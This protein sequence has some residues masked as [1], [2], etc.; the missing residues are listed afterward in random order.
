MSQVNN[1]SENNENCSLFSNE[2]NVKNEETNPEN[3][4]EKKYLN[5]QNKFIEN[6]NFTKIKEAALKN[7]LNLRHNDMM[8]LFNQRRIFQKK[9]YENLDSLKNKIKIPIELFEE[10]Q[11]ITIDYNQIGKYFADFFSNDISLKYKSLVCL[12]KILLSKA[13]LNEEEIA[14]IK[15][16][17][18]LFSEVQFLNDCFLLLNSS[19]PEFQYEAL[20]CL[21]G[22]INCIEE[23]SNFI[24]SK[25]GLNI[26]IK[27]FDSDIIEIQENSIS[28]AGNLMIQNP[29]IISQFISLKGFQKL[30]NI[31]S[32]S[33]NSSIITQTL[34]TISNCIKFGS[35]DIN[36]NIVKPLIKPLARTFLFIK[37]N[38]K[39]I[40]EAT[41]LLGSLSE[42]YYQIKEEILQSGIIPIIISLINKNSSKYVILSSLRI[43]GNIITGN[44]NQTQEIL[45]LGILNILKETLF[46][47]KSSI[48]KETAWILSNICS[49]TQ[50]QIEMIIDNGFFEL[51]IKCIKNDSLEVKNEIIWAITN[52]TI[53]NNFDYLNKIVDLGI[54]EIICSFLKEKSQNNIIVISLEALGNLLVFGLKNSNNGKNEIVER[55]INCGG[56]DDL[57]NLQYHSVEII[58]EKALYILENYFITEPVFQ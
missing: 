45:N 55:I 1:L 43:I 56:T 23:Y 46:H 6:E 48:R 16:E 15:N 20:L 11:N 4:I 9:K 10:S 37:N 57:E 50:K 29:E 14:K 35:F 28:L 30:T 13:D 58:Y 52:L 31:L 40:S 33:Q 26:I 54:V 19:Y 7:E 34:I 51:F 44:A 12:K 22:L 17:I 36:Y 8:K 32:N 47:D 5:R 41:W 42:K 39:F 53:V 49:G 3:Q 21:N 38:D 27:L 24:V 18:H 2:S 25:G